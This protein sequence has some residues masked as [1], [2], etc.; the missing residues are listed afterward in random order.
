MNQDGV[1]N[2]DDKVSFGYIHRDQNGLF[3]KTIIIGNE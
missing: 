2:V 1:I 3:E